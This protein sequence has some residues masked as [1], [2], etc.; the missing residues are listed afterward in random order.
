M[1]SMWFLLIMLIPLVGIV[2]VSWHTWSLL[3]LAKTWKWVIIAIGVVCFFLLFPV[4][5]SHLDGLPL[6]L[7]RMLYAIGTSSV[8]VLLYL[9]LVF[10]VLDVGRLVHL[11]SHSWL[12]GNGTVTVTLTVF[13]FAIFL[14]GNIHYKNKVRVELTVETSKPLTKDYIIVLASDLHLGYHN[15]RGDLAHWV[16][17]INAEEPDVVLIAGDI[18]DK[19][20]RPLQEEDMSAEFRRLNAPVYACLGN[21]EYYSHVPQAYQFYKEAG[22]RLL[23][24]S[25]AFDGDLCIIGRDDRTNRHRASLQKLKKQAETENFTLLLD[26]QPF[27]LEQAEKEGIDFQLSG[28]THEGQIWPISWITHTLYECAYGKYQRGNTNYYVSSGLGIWGG[29]FRIGTQSEYIVMKLHKA[30][31]NETHR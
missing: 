30:H 28:H 4:L 19:S 20:V 15:T 8:I 23:Q 21:H 31:K 26:H 5:F 22:I 12:Y 10:I 9:V 24:D 27:D 7:S 1:K 3:P 25:C 29:K 17:L 6:P 16:D 18:I 13:L 11:V 2:Y 14:Y